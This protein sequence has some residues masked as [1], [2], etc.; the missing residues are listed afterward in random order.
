MYL[1]VKAMKNLFIAVMIGLTLFVISCGSPIRPIYQ[2]V[3]EEEMKAEIDK[4]KAQRKQ[5]LVITR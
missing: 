5:E 2:V 4:Q 1:E 3:A